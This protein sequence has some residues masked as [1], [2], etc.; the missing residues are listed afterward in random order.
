MLFGFFAMEP[1]EYRNACPDH[2]CCQSGELS[3]PWMLIVIIGLAVVVN[4]INYR[5]NKKE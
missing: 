2:N 3:F 4:V 5:L 1:Q